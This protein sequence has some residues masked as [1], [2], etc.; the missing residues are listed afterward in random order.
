MILFYFF[1]FI[2][3]ASSI[4]AKFVTH[5]K[6]RSLD[7]SAS[8]AN[9]LNRFPMVFPHLKK[10]ADLRRSEQ[11]HRVTYLTEPL[12]FTSGFIDLRSIHMSINQ[13]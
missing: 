4:V 12:F 1:T 10:L 8:A 7:S 6:Q 5:L 9:V 2:I 13:H 3:V 11:K